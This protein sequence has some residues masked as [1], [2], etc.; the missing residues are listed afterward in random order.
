MKEIYPIQREVAGSLDRQLMGQ[1]GV[2]IDRGL[3]KTRIVRVVSR[4]YRCPAYQRTANHLRRERDA[5]FTLLYFPGLDATNY[6]AEQ[7][8]SSQ[9][10][11][12]QSL[13]GDCTGA[14]NQGVI[15]SIL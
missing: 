6:R 7:A 14:H 5:T 8:H 13:G 10:N 3:L 9:G 1:Q 4:N 15:V 11:H 2:A 12:K